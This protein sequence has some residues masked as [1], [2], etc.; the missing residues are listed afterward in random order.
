MSITSRISIAI[1]VYNGERF[2]QEQ[3]ETLVSQL[4]LP[5][6]V[7]VSDNASTDRTLEIVR[8]FGQSAPFQVHFTVNSQNL[9]IGQN[10]DCALRRCTGD[11]I[12]LCD[13]D[14]VWYPDKLLKI[15]ALFESDPEVALVLSDAHLVGE[16]LES[17]NST[18]WQSLGS[19]LGERPRFKRQAALRRY[20]SLLYG[21]TMAF[22]S[23][24]LDAILPI[25]DAPVFL[26]GAHDWWIGLLI[27]CLRGGATLIHE[28]LMKYRQH[29]GQQSRLRLRVPW[30]KRIEALSP[31]GDVSSS[32]LHFFTLL[33]ERIRN[34]RCAVD[35]EFVKELVSTIDHFAAR[36]RLP[37]SRVRRLIPLCRE[38]ASFRYHR[39][40]EGLLTATGDL[41]RPPRIARLARDKNS[42][43]AAILKVASGFQ[44]SAARKSDR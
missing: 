30:W 31:L 24:Y 9:G 7:V 40:A 32:A 33:L 25:P 8:R 13:S 16:N 1:A 6:E 12:C 42:R 10:F 23:K 18:L 14:D 27:L 5:D 26:S 4:R 15:A 3:L 37:D 41:L 17:L 2:I 21:N 39:L 28:P 34:L 11:I 22:R 35:E 36:E 20:R 19:P 44:E 38:L 29:D 43:T